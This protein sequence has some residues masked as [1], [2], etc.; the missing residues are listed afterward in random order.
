M[1][2]IFGTQVLAATMKIGILSLVQRYHLMEKLMERSYNP[3]GYAM[4][5]TIHFP[6]G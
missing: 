1:R 3:V 2:I 4:L 5:R 6:G